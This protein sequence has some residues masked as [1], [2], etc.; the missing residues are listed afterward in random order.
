M[1][2]IFWV[3][4]L[5]AFSYHHKRST[6][7]LSLGWFILSGHGQWRKGERHYDALALRILAS[8]IHIH[9]STTMNAIILILGF[10]SKRSLWPSQKHAWGCGWFAE[11]TVRPGRLR[12]WGM[13]NMV[14]YGDCCRYKSLLSEGT[15][16]RQF[17]TGQL[18][19]DFTALLL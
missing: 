2:Y 6:L 3:L 11:E 19:R 4:F 15:N 9:I 1:I 13:R 12:E 16:N 10:E 7:H 14:P 8:R 17:R 5:G 18:S